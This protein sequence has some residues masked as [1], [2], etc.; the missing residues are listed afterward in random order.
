[1]F[2]IS[3]LDGSTIGMGV[4]VLVI[5]LTLRVVA[6]FGA[7]SFGDMTLKERFFVALAWSHLSSFPILTVLKSMIVYI[8]IR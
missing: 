4:L 3:E 5:G 7:V 8:F 6:S 1:M 2:Q